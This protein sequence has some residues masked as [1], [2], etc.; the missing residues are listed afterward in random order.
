[1]CQQIQRIQSN[2][3]IFENYRK[4]ATLKKFLSILIFCVIEQSSTFRA[5][6]ETTA[7]IDSPILLEKIDSAI[8]LGYLRKAEAL[9]A[10]LSKKINGKNNWRIPYYWHL[11]SETKQNLI[12]S[13]TYILEAYRLNPDNP[14]LLL[15]IASLK[16][17]EG[18]FMIA[19]HHLNKAIYLKPDYSSAY[20]NR[21]V[22]KGA[23]G[24]TR[25][26]ILDFTRSV[27]LD[28]YNAMGYQNRGISFEIFGDM[29]NAC[30]DWRTASLLGLDASK[31]WYSVQCKDGT[32]RKQECKNKRNNRLL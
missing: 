4:V 30:R 15:S 24:D 2:H 25:G 27:E 29:K 19:L 3:D 31:Q 23:L 16:G 17:R 18:K 32:N 1:M 11:I 12:D 26:A 20:I 9:I 22:V 14:E 8:K 13:K 6:A 21:G 10:Q 5:A 7:F 28:K